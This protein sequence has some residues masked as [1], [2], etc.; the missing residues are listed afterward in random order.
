MSHIVASGEIICAQE[1]KNEGFLI[2]FVKM[3]FETFRTCCLKHCGLAAA[4]PRFPRV[5]AHRCHLLGDTRFLFCGRPSACEENA[6]FSRCCRPRSSASPTAKTFHS[7]FRRLKT[8]FGP[9]SAGDHMTLRGSCGRGSSAVFGRKPC[10]I[11]SEHR[12][13]E[14]SQHF[15]RKASLFIFY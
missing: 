10:L 3:S 1:K 13:S 5:S 12:F 8:C 6:G 15:D 2:S 14:V 7:C 4:S 9:V 11:F